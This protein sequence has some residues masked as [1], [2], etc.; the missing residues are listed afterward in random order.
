MLIALIAIDKP[1]ALEVR[2]AN[3][4]AHVAYLQDSGVVQQA[5]PFLS[6]EGEMCGSLIILDVADMEAAQAFAAGD[7]YGKAGLFQSVELRAWNRVI[8]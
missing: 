5:G 7:P 4:E 3:R 6:N 1:G 8:G 2:K